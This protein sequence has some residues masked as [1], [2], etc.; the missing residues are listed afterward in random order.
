MVKEH[1]FRTSS[2]KGEDDLLYDLAHQI[3]VGRAETERIERRVAIAL[4]VRRDG[5]RRFVHIAQCVRRDGEPFWVAHC[6]ALVPCKTHCHWCSHSDLVQSLYLLHHQVA[7]KKL[8]YILYFLEMRREM[9]HFGE[10]L[11]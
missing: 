8:K 2:F 5:V 7:C 10:R 6:A 9:V 1:T 4:R 11:G 3:A